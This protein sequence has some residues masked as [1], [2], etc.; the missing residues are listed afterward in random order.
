MTLLLFSIVFGICTIVFKIQSRTICLR[1]YQ[2]L[3]AA[4]TL[5]VGVAAC[6]I[7]YRRSAPISLETYALLFFYASVTY[8]LI[9]FSIEDVLK[10]S[11]SETH[12]IRFT[13]LMLLFITLTAVFIRDPISFGTST[14][15]AYENIIVGLCLTAAAATLVYLT[16]EKAMGKADVYFLGIMGFMNGYHRTVN[17]VYVA[18]FTAL[19][20]GIMVA[21]RKKSIRNV[22]IP[23]IPFI[24]LGTILGF[25]VGD[26]SFIAAFL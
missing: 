3:E 16:K 10:R 23:F 4:L 11:V 7:I 13:G 5:G 14:F 18:I 17:G 12:I 20:F 22:R 8:T 19:L 9:S 26:H 1:K 21:Y 2:P 24:A 6:I 15:S 25:L